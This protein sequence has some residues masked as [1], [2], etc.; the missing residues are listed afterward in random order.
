AF[1][2]RQTKDDK[3]VVLDEKEEEVLGS[4][5][6]KYGDT[7]VFLQHLETGLWLSYKTYET[8]KRGVGKVEEKQVR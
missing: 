5:L 1:C 2:L 6:V 8:K 3:K 4:P 7:T